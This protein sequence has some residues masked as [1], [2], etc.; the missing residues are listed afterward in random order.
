MCGLRNENIQK[1]LL[2]KED[3]ALGKAVNTA[4][5]ME[6]FTNDVIELEGQQNQRTVNKIH[7]KA[8]TPKRIFM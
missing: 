6:T 1:N 7:M 8:P 5:A 3:L 4:V 2:S